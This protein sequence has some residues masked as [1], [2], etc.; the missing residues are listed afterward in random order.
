MAGRTG[1]TS[2]PASSDSDRQA[3]ESPSRGRRTCKRGVC[4]RA[5]NDVN[6]EAEQAETNLGLIHQQKGA[7][8]GWQG[9]GRREGSVQ[10][11]P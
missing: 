6:E 3:I 1:E 9:E 5:Q 11:E 4:T 10:E 2:A 8:G 7:E